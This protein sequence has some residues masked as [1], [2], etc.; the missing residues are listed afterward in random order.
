MNTNDIDTFE[1]LAKNWPELFEKAN[2]NS[3]E[4]DHG[5]FNIINTLCSLIY[6][7]VTRLQRTKKVYD[8]AE[9]GKFKDEL[10]KECDV[11]LKN[12]IK[13]LPVIHQIKEKFGGLRFYASNLTRQQ[14]YY[15]EFAESMSINTC[16]F[17]GNIGSLRSRPIKT[18]CDV[19]HQEITIEGNY[20]A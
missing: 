19:H 15:I 11:Q 20:V 13:D 12:A 10:I 7:D 18:L 1:E 3:V 9:P 2:A 8:E 4:A 14:E 6:D 16:E 5:W 17:C